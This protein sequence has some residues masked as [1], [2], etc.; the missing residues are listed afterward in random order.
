MEKTIGIGVTVKKKPLVS[1][2]IPVYNAAGFLSRCVESILKQTYTSLEII[3]IND[4]SKDNSGDLCDQYTQIDDRIK[5][6]HQINAGVSAARNAGLKIAT[7]DYIGFVDSDDWIDPE[8]YTKMVDAALASSK[9]I[10]VCGH[11]D[12][13]INGAINEKSFE[14]L[15]GSMETNKSLQVLLSDKYFE[16]YPWNKMFDKNIVQSVRFDERIHFCEDVLFCFQI[17]QQSEGI[18]Y[19]PDVLY[20]HCLSASSAMVNFNQKRLTEQKAWDKI[21]LYAE[22][23]SK[24]LTRLAKHR[25][26]QAAINI[27]YM[28]SNS[29]AEQYTLT[30]KDVRY[31]RLYFTSFLV[32]FRYKVNGLL[33]LYLPRLT[34]RLWL[35]IKNRKSVE[36]L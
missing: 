24:R 14:N 18:I 33:K 16:G 35:W 27:F 26:T 29:P 10:I 25:Y 17:F 31:K 23:I 19:I 8:M 22:G 20:H 4:G 28:Q 3:L 5:V 1:I 11:A 34:R 6:I 13:R 36:S 12:Y 9:K 30:R 32:P 2:I 7:G 15:A 21:I